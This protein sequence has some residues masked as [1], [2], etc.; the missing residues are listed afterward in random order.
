MSA[1]GALT[2]VILILT[3]DLAATCYYDLCTHGVVL[4]VLDFL[5]FRATSKARYRFG[6]CRGDT[7]YVLNT[8]TGEALSTARF[9]IMPA[10]SISKPP[11]SPPSPSASQSACQSLI[12]KAL[13]ART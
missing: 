5:L 2:F 4:E 11:T 12:W 13:V 7:P 8:C 10:M 1:A 3:Q 9:P 6:K